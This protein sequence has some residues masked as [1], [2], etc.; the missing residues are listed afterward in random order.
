VLWQAVDREA[1]GAQAGGYVPRL[2]LRAEP[3]FGP[4]T[5]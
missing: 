5:K 2:R 4:I 1:A 3:Y